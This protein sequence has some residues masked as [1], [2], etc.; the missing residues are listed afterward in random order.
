MYVH[1]SASNTQRAIAPPPELMIQAA[2]L[3]A[4]AQAQALG[5]PF[6]G[7]AVLPPW[8]RPGWEIPADAREALDL[9][10]VAGDRKSTRLNSSH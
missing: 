2:P 1:A 5:G 4:L 10:G 8:Q 9:G 7:A 3:E 6:Y